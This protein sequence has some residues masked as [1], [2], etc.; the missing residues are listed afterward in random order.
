MREM[1][2]GEAFVRRKTDRSP[3]RKLGYRKVGPSRW[4]WGILGSLGN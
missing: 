1:I 2:H 3:D 4:R